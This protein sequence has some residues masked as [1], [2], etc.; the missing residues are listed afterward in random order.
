[1]LFKLTVKNLLQRPL[2][3]VLTS[4]AITFSVAAVSAVF[5]F[6]GGL[7][8]TF[9]G[10]ATNLESGYDIAVQPNIDFGGG[11]VAPSV[12]LENLPLLQSIEGVAEVSPRVVGAGVIP[13]DGQG[14]P[15]IA[16]GGPNLAVAWGDDAG[17][18]ARYFVQSGRRPA[19]PDEFALDID[20]FA[21]GAYELGERYILQ[22]PSAEIEGR[23]FELT[24]TFTFGDP[25]RN[26]L[27]GARIV[28]FDR[29]PAVELLNNGTGFSDITLILDEGAEAEDVIS[30]VEAVVDE[31]LNVL[32]QDEVI[33]QTQGD[34]GQI[35]TIFQTVLLVFAVIIAGVSGF[36]IYNVFSITLGQRIRE[37]GLL[38]A[39][40]ALG[41]QVTNLMIGEALLLGVFSTIIGIPAGVGMAWLLRTALIALGFPDDTGLPLGLGTVV[42]AVALGVGGT[43][44]AAI[45]PS[46]QARRVAPIAALRDGAN[47]ED[48]DLLRRPGRATVELVCV[49]ILLGLTFW[50]TGWPARLFLPLFAALFLFDGVRQLARSLSR[51]VVLPF[52][53]AL[54][55]VVLFG[56]FELG[57]TFSLLGAATTV[58]IFGAILLAPSLVRPV[59]ALVGKSPTALLVGLVGVALA[60]T[61]VA[62]FIGAIFVAIVGTPDAVIDAAQSDVPR[63]GLVIPLA[64]AGVL[65]AILGYAIVRTAIGA[66]GLTGQIARSNA[67]RNP[68]RTSTTAAALVVGITLVAMVTVVGDSIKASVSNALSSSIT[69]DWLLQGPQGGPGGTPF[70]T[71][72]ANRVEALDEVES[73]NR[74]RVAFPAAWVTSDSGELTAA[75]FQEFLP[76]VLELLDDDADLDPQRLLQLRDQLG[77]DVQINDAAAVDFDVLDDHINPDFIER[78]V[79][80]LG[81]NAIYIEQSVAEE[82]GLEVGD[83]FSALFIDLQ[84][85]DLV[86]AGIYDNGF[87]LG[88]RVMSLDLWNRHFPNDSDQFL[89]VITASGVPPED[90]RAAIEGELETDFPIINVQT[91]AEFAEASERQ[92]NQTLATVNVLL[93]LS[94]LIAALGILLALALSVFERT[95]EIGLFR[96]VGATRQQTRWIIRW[97]GV[98]VAAFGGLVGVVLGVAIG[99]LV[100]NKLPEFLVTETS[101]PVATLAIYVLF[102]A[103]VGL[104]A[105][106]FPAWT[107]GR[108]NVL[109]AISSE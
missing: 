70:S 37:L 51:F 31:D 89:T 98:I 24:G 92:I 85:E 17:S 77:T 56:D 76:I 87:V 50:F 83:T 39:I 68:Q 88:N 8:T 40:G 11:F 38:R 34:F 72:V 61:A 59:T 97:E 62:A 105:A 25:D 103:I 6:T 33:E 94:G 100:T 14:V 27:V 21:E 30:R 55:L 2:R 66:R 81:P 5:I 79:S 67:T 107:A 95:R 104:F 102:A 36:L 108:M 54:L 16:G 35:L 18:A 101:V 80:L 10:L 9:D 73:V 26:A 82:R 42:I 93:G 22:S 32:T 90:A 99:I 84:S 45:W 28:A 15:T 7:R 23:T 63:Q 12:P 44:L 96:A 69:A 53:I 49:P 64:V 29:D 58:T 52:G 46:I 106:V 86:V 74:F 65:F 57:Q 4:I 1:M 75:D 20:A 47:I 91:R 41:S 3:Y 71:E 109:E 60:V 13:V 19:S 48:L 78:D 43:A